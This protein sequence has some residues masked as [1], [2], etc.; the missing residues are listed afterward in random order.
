M[1]KEGDLE[2]AAR[3]HK[4]KTGVG[5]GDFHS[6]VLLDLT[7]EI[8]E[9]VVGFLEKEEQ[10]GTW[11][12]QAC[13]TMILLIRKNVTSERPIVLMLTMIRWSKALRAPEVAK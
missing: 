10:T 4:A 6:K 9:E 3:L 12:H 7:R 8:R 2:K 1:F 5:Y 11:P 13:G